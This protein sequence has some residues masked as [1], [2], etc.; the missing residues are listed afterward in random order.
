MIEERQN[1]LQNIANRET[2]T[3]RSSSGEN[4]RRRAAELNEHIDRL[5]QLLVAIN[6]A[7]PDTDGYL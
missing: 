5:K 7:E 2:D 6:K 3:G 1:V 4:Y